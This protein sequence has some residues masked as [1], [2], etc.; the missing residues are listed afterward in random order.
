[1]NTYE[2]DAIQEWNSRTPQKY[3]T[4]SVKPITHT[5]G[6]EVSGVDLSKDI[7][8]EQIEE[9]RQAWMENLVLVFRNQ[10][11]SPEDHKRF[12]RKFGTLHVHPLNALKNAKDLEILEVKAAKGSKTVAGESWHTDVSC[13]PAPP[14]ASM[15]YIKEMP[16]TKIGG[17]TMFA[18]MYLAYDL[19]SPPIKKLLEGLTAIHDAE[20]SY[21]GRYNYKVPEGGFP[22]SEHPV[23]VRHPETGRKVLFVNR[24]FTSHIVQMS[25]HES[26]S[27]LEMLFRNIELTPSIICRIPWTTNSMVMWDNRCTLHHAV[28]DYLPHSRYGERVT[29]NGSQPQP[30]L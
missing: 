19:L 12:G 21:V 14:M 2:L 27:I 30:C 16:E 26:N 15:L 18:N 11:M 4:I 7:S 29:V 17:D 5:I 24:G 6:A 22:R 10:N 25:Q 23:V 8:Q 9:I 3:E 20:R 28:W 13:D 1:M